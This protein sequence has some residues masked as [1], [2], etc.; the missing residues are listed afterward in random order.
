MA[1]DP[2]RYLRETQPRPL[3]PCADSASADPKP[4]GEYSRL[5]TRK[6]VVYARGSNARRRDG[7]DIVIPNTSALELVKWD[8]HA[9]PR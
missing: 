6:H 8:L 1:F 3:A 2:A 5:D 4:C 9:G 7:L